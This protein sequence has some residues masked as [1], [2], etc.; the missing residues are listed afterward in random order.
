MAIF[1]T[2]DAYENCR[3]IDFGVH[4]DSRGLL[5]VCEPPLLPFVPRRVFYIRDVPAGQSRGDHAHHTIA[6]CLI[7][8]AGHLDLSWDD[9]QRRGCVQLDDPDRGFYIPP[10]IWRRME[11]F[12]SDALLLVLCSDMYRDADYIRNYSDFLQSVKP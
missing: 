7:A 6:E 10:R 12:S 4:R 1:T 3:W 8:L 9:G 5:T 2:D 11:A